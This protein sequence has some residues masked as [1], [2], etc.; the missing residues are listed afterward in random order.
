MLVIPQVPRAFDH[1]RGGSVGMKYK[2]VHDGRLKLARSALTLKNH[3]PVLAPLSNIT[4]YAVSRRLLIR[5][6]NRFQ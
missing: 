4:A 6:A 1:V 5:P 2:Y 3:Q